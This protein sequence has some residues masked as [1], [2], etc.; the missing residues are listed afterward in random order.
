M[1]NRK[2]YTINVTDDSTMPSYYQRD[3][4]TKYNIFYV[5]SLFH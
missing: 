4:I 3:N 1:K 2:N 5:D